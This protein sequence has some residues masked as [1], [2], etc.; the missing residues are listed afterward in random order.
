MSTILITGGSGL[1]G[2]R[3]STL[4][5][6]K[7]H[8]VRHLSRK[9]NNNSKF[10]TFLWNLTTGSIDEK[11]FENVDHIIHLAGAGIADK[12]WSA[13]RK[14]VILD[15]RVQSVNLLLNKIKELQIPLKSFASSSA[16]GYYGSVTSETIF[17]ENHQPADDFLGFIC[18]EW[19]KAALKF[20]EE[21]I[22]TCIV[23]TGVVLSKQG[24]ALKKMKTPVITPLGSGKQYMPWIHV[25]DLC[26][27]FIKAIEDPKMNGAYNGVAPEHQTN[28]SFSKLLAKSIKRPY[29]PISAP[30]FVLKLVFG[31]MSTILLNGSRISSEK[32]R[33]EGFKYSYPDLKSTLDNILSTS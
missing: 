31:E 30:A 14:K 6:M 27:I 17:E 23:R 11:A 5:Q 25:D 32:I 8:E 15:S 2:N 29:I 26:K 22:R 4:L 13:S 12:R 9:E 7:G 18:K 33:N 28:T 20:Q 10:A 16:I 3:L 24:G 21:N 1:I 19:E